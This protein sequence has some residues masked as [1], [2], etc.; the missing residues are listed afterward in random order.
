MIKIFNDLISA[1]G[2][3]KILLINNCRI[4]ANMLELLLACA[5]T[6][7]INRLGASSFVAII[8]AVVLILL[9]NHSNPKHIIENQCMSTTSKCN[10][11][12]K[13]VNH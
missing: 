5:S 3:R 13:R 7:A 11:I 10:S 1:K 9:I 4:D 8:F 2:R 12:V 6:I